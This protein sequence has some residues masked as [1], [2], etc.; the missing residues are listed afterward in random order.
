MLKDLLALRLRQL[1]DQRPD[2]DTQTK[3]AQRAG[4]GQ[5][6]VARI[7]SREVHTSLDVVEAL[8]GAFGIHPLHLLTDPAEISQPG[9][10]AAGYQERALLS[11]WRLLAPAQQHAVMGYLH[12]VT[13]AQGA[14]PT[15]SPAAAAESL[16][17]DAISHVPDGA[18]AAVRRAAAR[19]PSQPTEQRHDHDDQTKPRERVRRKRA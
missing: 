13:L 19:Q 17:V 12:V 10:V 6:T 7:L 2:L 5:S 18:K 1:M 15:A 14:L 4:V 8:A 16:Q 9:A 11:A 3:V